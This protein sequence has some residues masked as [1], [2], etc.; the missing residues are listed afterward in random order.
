MA[1]FLLYWHSVQDTES[2][3]HGLRRRQELLAALNGKEGGHSHTTLALATG[4]NTLLPAA[5]G[6]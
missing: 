4:T 5:E 3:E 1:L 2:L 6:V